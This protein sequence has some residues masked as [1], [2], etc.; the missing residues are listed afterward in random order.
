[1]LDFSLL[2]D[3][4]SVIKEVETMLLC[5]SNEIIDTTQ[6]ANADILPPGNLS[7]S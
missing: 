4:F 5:Y 1:M 3:L 6:A 2:T 7:G